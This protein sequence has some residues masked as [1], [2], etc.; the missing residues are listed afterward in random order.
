MAVLLL[1][2]QR[3]TS[4]NSLK[5]L[6]RLGLL[7][8][9]GPGL[10][11][12]SFISQ[13]GRE[14]SGPSIGPVAPRH[15]SQVCPFL[16]Q[17][18]QAEN[19]DR[20]TGLVC[21][22]YE[23]KWGKVL[24]KNMALSIWTRKTHWTVDTRYIFKILFSLNL[25]LSK[26]KM[27]LFPKKMVDT[28]VDIKAGCSQLSPREIFCLHRLHRGFKGVKSLP[29]MSKVKWVWLPGH[30]QRQALEIQRKILP[31]CHQLLHTHSEQITVANSVLNNSIRLIVLSERQGQKCQLHILMDPCLK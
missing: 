6:S 20:D 11:A 22:V 9:I 1:G 25:T 3:C 14:G 10:A 29:Q 13:S 30:Q 23:M 28:S 15:L 4:G 7:L 24:W 31:E 19:E 12:T 5:R 26:W 18:S 16:L 27:G 17:L 2:F 21:E 8:S